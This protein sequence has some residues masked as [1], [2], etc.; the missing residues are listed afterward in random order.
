[1]QIEFTKA[2]F[3]EMMDLGV[4]DIRANNIVYYNNE[5]FTIETIDKDNKVILTK[6]KD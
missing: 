6:V 4:V 5:K 3:R 1:M 2:E